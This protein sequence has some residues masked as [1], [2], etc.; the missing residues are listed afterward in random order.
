MSYVDYS[1]QFVLDQF[2]TYLNANQLGS[3]DQHLYDNLAIEHNLNTATVDGTHKANS[4]L[5]SYI[6]KNPITATS[7]VINSGANWVPDPGVYQFVIDA[8]VGAYNIFVELFISGSWRGAL[9]SGGAQD[10]GIVLCDGVNVRLANHDAGGV[11][12]YYQK[13]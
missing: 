13:F 5:G 11:T 3:N 7:R 1:S 8:S 4:I 10:S 2:L 12:I 6:N 9:A